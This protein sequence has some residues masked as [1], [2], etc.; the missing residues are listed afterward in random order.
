MDYT[1]TLLNRTLRMFNF[2]NIP[3]SIDGD[4][5]NRELIVHGRVG[6]TTRATD[7]TFDAPRAWRGFCGGEITEFYT[8]SRFIGASPVIGSCDFKIDGDGVVIY[9][10]TED[11]FAPFAGFGCMPDLEFNRRGKPVK[12]DTPKAYPTTALYQYIERTADLLSNIDVST[13]TLLRTCRALI[14]ITAKDE[15]TKTAAEIVLSKLYRGEIDCVMLSNIF[16]SINIS[17]APTAANAAAL[18]SEYKEQYQFCLAQ[19]YNAIG[20]NANYNLKRER[21]NVAE[22]DVNEQSLIVNIVDMLK[23]RREGVE[24]VNNMFG[25]DITVSLGEEWRKPDSTETAQEREQNDIAKDGDTIDNA[26]EMEQDT[27]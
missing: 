23:C 22:I 16:D 27:N 9:N 18:L 5:L 21:L 11:K 3:V 7:K 14:I 6:I 25:T 20:I 8:G 1:Q 15:Q 24:R 10:T 2:E 19:F 13:Q 17:Y 4:F 26:D 12:A